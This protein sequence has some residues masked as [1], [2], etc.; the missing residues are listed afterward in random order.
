MRLG[1]IGSGNIGKSIGSWAAKVGY[2]V[3]FSAEGEDHARKAA[4]QSGHGATS[5]TVREAVEQSEL[6]LLAVPGRP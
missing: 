4:E 1:T 2:D 5:G 3:I 6:V